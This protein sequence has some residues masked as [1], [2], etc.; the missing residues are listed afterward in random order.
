M[1][2]DY[3]GEAIYPYFCGLFHHPFIPVWIFGG[4]Y[5]Q[6]QVV[7]VPTPSLRAL[8]DHRFCCCGVV[9]C[10][11]AAIHRTSSVYYS[12]FVPSSGPKDTD[13]VGGFIFAKSA[14]IAFD[15]VRKEYFHVTNIVKIVASNQ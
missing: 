7:R 13:A 4:A 8:D 10:K 15:T 2:P 6:F 9:I 1:F 3:W 11:A 12:D 14:N 5:C